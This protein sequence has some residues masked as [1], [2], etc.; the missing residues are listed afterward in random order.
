MDTL[1][2]SASTV[3]ICLI[4]LWSGSFGRYPTNEEHRA[5]KV[6]VY[7]ELRTKIRQPKKNIYGNTSLVQN[8]VSGFSRFLNQLI[9]PTSQPVIISTA[10]LMTFVFFSRFP[11]HW[12]LLIW[13]TTKTHLST[14]RQ[15]EELPVHN[16]YC[17]TF[18]WPQCLQHARGIWYG[19]Q[20]Q[21]KQ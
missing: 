16:D 7:L 10:C 4:Q 5:R 3:V 14:Q 17:N 12:E 1:T 2:H 18:L 9:V 19:W 13:H 11:G 21:I 15:E 8:A 6:H 20:L